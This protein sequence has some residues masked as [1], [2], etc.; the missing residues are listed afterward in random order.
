[1]YLIFDFDG[2]LV[3]SY[4]KVL[5]KFNFLAEKF[6]FKK[7]NEHDLENLKDLNSKQLIKFLNIPFYK[8]PRIIYHARKQMHEEILNL[9]PFPFIPEVLKQC[10]DAGFFLGIL[11]SNSEENVKIWLQHHNIAHFFHFIHIESSYFGKKKILKRIIN[12]YDIDKSK[13]FYIGDETRDV[14]AAKQAGIYSIAVTWGFNS[15]KILL[16]QQP[17]YVARTPNDIPKILNSLSNK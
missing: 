6:K 10:Y 4:Q 2:T 1:M 11:T 13:A 5:E 3:D 14:D 16:Q 12:N 9:A 7:I 17:H 8:M 15:E